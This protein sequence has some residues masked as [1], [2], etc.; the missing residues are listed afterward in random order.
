[1]NGRRFENGNRDSYTDM[2]YGCFAWFS[3]DFEVKSLLLK[4]PHTSDFKECSLN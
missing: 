3:P 4:I 1:M 2:G